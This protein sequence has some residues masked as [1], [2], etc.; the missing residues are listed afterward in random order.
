MPRSFTC[1]VVVDCERGEDMCRMRQE[2]EEKCNT[3]D[4]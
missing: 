2:Q 4:T 1:C 3:H